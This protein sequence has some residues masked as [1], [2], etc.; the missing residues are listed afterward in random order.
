MGSNPTE[1]GSTKFCDNDLNNGAIRSRASI[2][3]LDSK[4]RGYG[5]TVDPQR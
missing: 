5:G 2:E 1:L 4:I 3:I